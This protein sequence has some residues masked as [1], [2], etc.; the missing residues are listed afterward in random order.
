MDF[1][2]LG[3]YLVSC[4]Q[5]SAVELYA[6]SSLAT[7]VSWL[8]ERKKVNTVHA[9]NSWNPNSSF[10]FVSFQHAGGGQETSIIEMMMAL[11]KHEIPDLEKHD[12]TRKAWIT[13]D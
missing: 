3:H 13:H 9:Q 2:W 7:S 5:D 12:M 10:Q 1:L 11:E 6:P 4:L 8:G